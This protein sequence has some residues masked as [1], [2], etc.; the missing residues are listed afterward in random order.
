MFL[1]SIWGGLKSIWGEI[2]FWDNSKNLSGVKSKNQ[3]R[4]TPALL[5]SEEGK[6]HHHVGFA[7]MAVMVSASQG[8][9][10]ELEE[11][12][13]TGTTDSKHA[14]PRSSQDDSSDLP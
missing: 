6:V 1:K 3:R 10:E 5:G 9:E 11:E 13:E 8:R 12:E 2:A 7:A 4:S 14:L